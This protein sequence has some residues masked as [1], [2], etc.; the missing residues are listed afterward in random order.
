M[1]KK[2]RM[3]NG[4]VQFDTPFLPKPMFF[5][6]AK[7]RSAASPSPAVQVRT[8]SDCP[9]PALCWPSAPRHSPFLPKDHSQWLCTLGPAHCCPLTPAVPWAGFLAS[10][11]VPGQRFLLTGPGCLWG[12]NLHLGST[13]CLLGGGLGWEEGSAGVSSVTDDVHLRQ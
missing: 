7:R 12:H 10:A 9:W 8:P 5:R 2:M 4:F 6:K 1:K 13:G 3:E 11:S